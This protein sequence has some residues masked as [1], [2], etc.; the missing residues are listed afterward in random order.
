MT[1]ILPEEMILRQPP[2]AQ[3]IIR[4]LLAKIAE[5]EAKLN[6][7]P[8]NSSLPPSTQHPHAKPPANKPKSKRKQG[9][10]PG[11]A[12]HERVLISAEQ[13]EAIYEH[14]PKACR[15]CGGKLSGSDPA[16]L[17]HQVWELPE[18]KPLV[19]EHRRHR[20]TCD[21][22]GQTTCG[23]LPP[24]VP[25]GQA[26]PRLIAFTALLMGSYRQSK[27]KA[28]Q[29]LTQIF[30]MPC[31]PG[32]VVKLQNQ[33]TAAVRPDYDAL[34]ALLPEQEN[35]N[36]DESP[37]K[38]AKLKTWLW[39]F[40]AARFTVFALRMTRKAEEL[41]AHVGEEF[42]G[43]AGCD[44]AKMYCRLVRVQWCWA[45][46]I[47]DFQALIDSGDGK[48]KRLG[49]DLMREVNAMFVL[50]GRVRDGTMTRH[51]FKIQMSPI[52]S[53]VED[54]LL[55]GMFSGNPRLMGMCEAIWRDRANLWT[56]VKVEGVEPTNNSAER[57]LRHAVIWRKLSF[58]TQSAGGNRFVETMLTVVETCR[59]QKKNAFAYLNQAIAAHMAG[60]KAAPLLDGA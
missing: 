29:F 60:K 22:C 54:L 51:G 50:W 23:D 46:L 53:N 44:R 17:R 25:Q 11:H 13:C 6:K 19:T 43:T 28:A 36:I 34:V 24:G 16:P 33:A 56:F 26:G 38:Q 52:R 35:L 15:G 30:D 47:R 39:V 8:Q 37:H 18:I 42:Q 12:K 49:H 21:G 10:Q 32:W 45:H 31:S 41:Y 7:T 27:R 3:A 5:L 4:L 2:E 20:L 57:A 14:R 1:L 59:Q 48:S 9:G 40:V 58:G 55:R